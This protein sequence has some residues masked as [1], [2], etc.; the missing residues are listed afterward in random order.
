MV[1]FSNN[2][3]DQMKEAIRVGLDIQN[4]ALARQRNPLNIYRARL[5]EQLA[6]GVAGRLAM[7][8]GRSYS[9]QLHRPF[10]RTL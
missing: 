5:M 7:Q 2:Y 9:R 1:F 6:V 10:Q 3:D 4:E 8:E